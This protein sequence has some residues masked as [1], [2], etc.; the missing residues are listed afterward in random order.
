MSYQRWGR[1]GKVAHVLGVPEWRRAL[2]MH[3]VAAGTEHLQM[4]QALGPVQTIIDV[5]ANRG[6]FALAARRAWPQATIVSFEPLS[7]P[8]EIYRGVFAAD[9]RTRLVEAA[10]GAAP[11]QAT[12]H[13]SGRDDSSSLLPITTMQSALFPGT[14]EVA[15]QQVRVTRLADELDHIESP[16][17]L[18]LDVQ[19]FELQAL[20]G[21]EDLLDRLDWIYVECSFVELYAGQAL[22]DE[23]IAWLRERGF[24]LHGVHNMAYDRSGQAIQ[25]DFLFARSVR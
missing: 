17:L 16:A 8:A 11:E 22:A 14:G 1:L 24:A 25:A 15:A 3:G 20:R 13:V 6:Q 21:C 4:L 7:G 5:G 12:I 10:L 23:V 9:G 2:R 19:G 18:K